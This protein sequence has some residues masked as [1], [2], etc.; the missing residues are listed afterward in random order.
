MHTLLKTKPQIT[1]IGSRAQLCMQLEDKEQVMLNEMF[2]KRLETLQKA[3]NSLKRFKKKGKGMVYQK[4]TWLK[5]ALSGDDPVT[6]AFESE[7]ALID[8]KKLPKDLPLEAAAFS[9]A[10]RFLGWAAEK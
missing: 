7:K 5:L 10:E 1:S 2:F 6:A 8:T 3:A 4:D 9:G